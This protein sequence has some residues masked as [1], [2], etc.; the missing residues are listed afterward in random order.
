[1]TEFNRN[2]IWAKVFVETLKEFNVKF[3]ILCPGSRNTPLTLAFASEKTITSFSVVDERSA[4]FVAFGIAAATG[5][6]VVVVTT[7]GTAAVELYP[8]IVEAYQQRVPLIVCTADR[9]AEL[10][11]TGANQTINQDN[12]YAN[13]IRAFYDT[14]LPEPDRIHIGALRLHTRRLITI[15]T[16]LN[17]GPVHF[18]FPF[19][20]PFESFAYTDKADLHS[21]LQETEESKF[22]PTPPTVSTKNMEIENFI[23]DVITAK[24]ILILCGPSLPF[25]QNS[26]AILTIAKLFNAVIFPDAASGL[27]FYDAPFIISYY[28]AL[29]KNKQFVSKFQPDIILQ[30]GR[31]PTSRSLE[32]FLEECTASRYIINSFG[33]NFD[34]LRKKCT[35]LPVNI[36]DVLPLLQSASAQRANDSTFIEHIKSFH[37]KSV[38]V[39]EQIFDNEKTLTGPLCA[40][41]ASKKLPVGSCIMPGNSMPIRD[42]DYFACAPGNFLTVFQNRG[43]SGIDGILSTAAGL[44]IGLGKPLTLITGDLSFYYDINA[45]YFIRKMKI[46]LTVILINNKGGGIFGHLPVVKERKYFDEYFTTPHDL[47]FKEI[48]ASFGVKFTRLKSRKAFEKAIKELNKSKRPQVFEVKTDSAKEIGLRRKIWKAVSALK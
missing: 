36:N 34:P 13:H 21:L 4:G 35:V 38:S 12:L 2:Y 11:N 42:F 32:D 30:F 45:L 10:R 7:S 17:P 43:A 44:C 6:P 26:N 25:S 24:N 37:N 3:A 9:P 33:D 5:H 40:F 27:R 20:K 22:S 19:K 15:A 31:F 41:L 1:M 8:A 39:T 18:N 47:N 23:S 14:G 29:L 48:T 46:P 28:D 16:N